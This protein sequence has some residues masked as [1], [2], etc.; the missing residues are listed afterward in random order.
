MGKTLKERLRNWTTAGLL[1][2]G[3]LAYAVGLS[4]CAGE[5]AALNETERAEQEI[6]RFLDSKNSILTKEGEYDVLS[7]STAEKS[8]F[9]V[10]DKQGGAWIVVYNRGNLTNSQPCGYEMST[11]GKN[12][13]ISR[14][15]KAKSRTKDN[16]AYTRGEELY[17]GTLPSEIKE[18]MGFLD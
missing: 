11:D 1:T 16:T 5:K 10:R 12:A 17:N 18:R 14:I 13:Q 4:G 15:H 2:A 9:C 6:C 8:S 3:G 7:Q